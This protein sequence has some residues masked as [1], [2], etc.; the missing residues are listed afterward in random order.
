MLQCEKCFKFS[1]A[2]IGC[3]LSVTSEWSHGF[4]GLDAVLSWLFF[5]WSSVISMVP[6]HVHNREIYGDCQN[7]VCLSD[8]IPRPFWLQLCQTGGIGVVPVIHQK[9]WFS[10]ASS[11][12]RAHRVIC[13]VPFK[14]RACVAAQIIRKRHPAVFDCRAAI[15]NFKLGIKHVESGFWTGVNLM[16]RN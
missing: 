15:F 1:M 4:T 11:S 9:I 6:P 7:K 10:V 14:L 8:F 3:N 12:V 13:T 5:N 16:W 2:P